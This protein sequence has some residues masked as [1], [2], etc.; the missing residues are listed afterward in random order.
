MKILEQK[1][2]AD[3]TTFKMGGVAEKIYFP[4]N[5]DELIELRKF[6]PDIYDYLIGGGSNLLINDNRKFKNVICLKNFNNGINSQSNGKYYV[7]A[8]VRLQKLIRTINVEGYGGIE[9]LFTV[10]GLVGGAVYMNAGRGEKQKKNISDYIL[11]VDCLV[12]GVLTTFQKAECEFAYRASVF[13]KIKGVIII[14][15]LFQFEKVSQIHA[16]K[17]ISWRIELCQKVQDMSYPNFGTVF[18]K[19]NRYIIELAKILH[20]G[21]ANG[22]TFSPKT[23]NWLLHRDDGSFEQTIKLISRIKKIHKFFGQPCRVEVKIWN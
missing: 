19:S 10:P 17:E 11:S 7:G 5:V 21:Y 23:K 6:D 1:S 9:Y 18:C 16:E 4:E 13:Q 8:S 3:Y 14:G 22:I 12:D 20:F 15:G 2:L